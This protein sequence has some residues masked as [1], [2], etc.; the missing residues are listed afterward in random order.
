[1]TE[2]RAGAG[3]RSKETDPDALAVFGGPPAFEE[4]LHVG[5][6]NVGSRERLRER[7]EDMLGRRWLT[8]DGPFVREFESRVAER[9][10]VEHCVAVCNA[11]VGLEMAIRATGLRGEVIVPS[12]TFVATAHALQWQEIKPVFCD[13]DPETHNLDPAQAERLIT[14]RTTGII[15][16]HVWGRPC[17][18]EPLTDLAARR[19]LVLLFDSAHAFGCRHGGRPIGGFGAAEVF[20]FH[21]TKVLNTGEGGAIVT[22]DDD[23]A[24]RLR[25]IRN[26][27]FADYDRVVALGTNG[28]MPEM[29]AALGLVNLESLEEFVAVNRRNY[30]AYQRGLGGLPGVS[31]VP[32]DERES[33]NYHYVVADWDAEAIGLDRDD[34]VAI[35]HAENVLA[36]RYFYPGCHRMEPYRTSDPDAGARL[37]ETERL[38]ERVLVLPTGTAVDEEDIAGVCG[39]LRNLVRSAPTIRERLR[40]LRAGG[41]GAA[42]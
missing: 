26:F 36:R 33:P 19:G 28:K 16:V 30:R 17:A 3:W 38:V 34:A 8:N 4:T 5:R 27:G 37:P 18:V 14:E 1:V 35:L 2:P 12:F 32:H 15:G 9:A 7:I 20:S 22:A 13:V 31:I 24:S 23:L 25:F 6:P 21:A 10:G 42:G 41:G 39:I 40:R 29:A 11:T